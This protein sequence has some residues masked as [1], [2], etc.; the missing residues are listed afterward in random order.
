MGQVVTIGLDIAK[1]VFQ[2]H[3]I[4]AEGGVVIRQKLTRARLLK[5]FG[6]LRPCLVGIEACGT[7]HHW[8]RELIGLGHD[9]RLMP[10]SYVK[11]YVKRQKND[12]AD[13]EAICE[14]VSRPTM[15]FVPVKSP[16]QQSIMVLHRTRSILIRQ[17]TQV[18]NAIRSHM[19]EFG[20][21][22]A[23]GRQGLQTLIEVVEDVADPRVP[24][25]ARGCLTMLV[26]QLR[27]SNAQ[28]LEG[29][30][31]IRTNARSTEVGRRLMEIPGVGPLLASAL[32]G[33]IADPKAFKTGRNLAAWIGLV[34]RQNSSGGKERL[35]GITKQ[36]DRYLRQMLV[37]GALAVVRYAVRNGTRRPWLVQLLARRTPKVAAV[38]LANKTARMVWAIMTSGERYREPLAA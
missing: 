10:P 4:D 20:M 19:A 1:S 6:K 29:D 28:I 31:L 36:G 13:A 37:V 34:P 12:M 24:S 33:T 14:A 3:G 23:I 9:V 7:A 22:A 2:V 17:R 27:L 30:R 11:P 32:V 35:G 21:A 38:A 25:E 16:E 18:S 15:R 26:A 5:F 8:A